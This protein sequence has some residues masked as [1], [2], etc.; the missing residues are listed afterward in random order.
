MDTKALGSIIKEARLSKKM[1][2]NEVV[3][4][5]ITR[6]M[7]SQIESGTA[8]PSVKTLDYL[9]KVL[10]IHLE[11]SELADSTGSPVGE[12]YLNLRRLFLAGDYDKI[13]NAS[14]SDDYRDELTALKA[15]AY[16]ELAKQMDES[17]SISDDQ[18]AVEYAKKAQELS[19]QG[20][21]ADGY[22]EEKAAEV[23]SSSAKRLKDYYSSLI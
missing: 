16:L 6:N 2:Q 4:D 11:P 8:M 21:F 15:R 1:T 9:C 5:F 22:I 7:L 18:L 19:K 3:G 20:I 13:V 14:C 23:I 10:D 17:V 12:S